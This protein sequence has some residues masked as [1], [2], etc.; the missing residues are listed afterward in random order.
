MNTSACR[1]AM[2]R[3]RPRQMAASRTIVSWGLL[4]LL[5][6]TNAWAET[7]R[8]GRDSQTGRVVALAAGDLVL[9]WGGGCYLRYPVSEQPQLHPYL[10][11]IVKVDFTRAKATVP[12]TGRP[13]T[14]IDA[15]T[16]VAR[17]PADLP[18]AITVRP[19]K[20][21]YRFG[22]V[23]RVAVAIEN[24]DKK[25]RRLH[26]GA[27]WTNLLDDYRRVLALEPEAHPHASRPY[28]LRPTVILAPGKKIGFTVH[29]ARMVAP[30]TYQL[31]YYLALE[32]GSASQSDVATIVVEPAKS[33]RAQKRVLVHWLTRASK[34]QRIE[35]ATALDQRGDPR[36]VAEILRMLRAGEYS[37][38]RYCNEAAFR[39]AWQRGRARGRRAMV[40]LIARQKNQ[41]CATKMIEAVVVSPDR[42]AVLGLLLADRHA[43]ARSTSGW[44]SKPRIA[45]IAAD[46]LVGYAG[47]KMTF[48]IAGS[49]AEREAAVANV[50]RQ[51][52]SN[53]NYFTNL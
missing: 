28:G 24:R 34:D 10:G 15:I 52:K 13:L 37:Q 17:K 30:G 3:R 40:A 32:P 2:R 44:V 27:S 36:G 9:F 35:V 45:D 5:S 46:W 6:V 50:A 1:A 18:V 39:F 7:L 47:G 19:S 8:P 31:A 33:H 4:S 23:I 26:L 22:D 21:R 29:S 14:R 11:S 43:V 51:L 41:W 38:A 48:P 12:F 42:V 53:P 49:Q 16:L 20:P 25:A